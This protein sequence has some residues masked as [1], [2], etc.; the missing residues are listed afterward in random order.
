M[1]TAWNTSASIPSLHCL[2]ATAPS[3][4]MSE[5]S[6]SGITK[7]ARPSLMRL[8]RG[9]CAMANSSI[10]ELP[11]DQRP[12]SEQFR[13]MSKQWADADNAAHLMDEMK[14]TVLA[15]KKNALIE[16]NPKMSDAAAERIVKAS[17][18]WAQYIKEMCGNRSRANV[19][20]QHLKYLEMRHREWI[21]ADANA[22]KEM[23]L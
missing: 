19:M 16:A 7:T 20:R 5:I 12:L 22:R 11:R 3:R 21:S 10:R 2:T 9:G 18:E 23:A 13:L 4:S 14:T 6:C 17:P 15:Q 1:R 8:D